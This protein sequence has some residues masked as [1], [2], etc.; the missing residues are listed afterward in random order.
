LRTVS[1]TASRPRRAWT[2]ALTWACAALLVGIAGCGGIKPKRSPE[3]TFDS[4]RKAIVEEDYEAMWGLLSAS[5]RQAE[6]ARISAQ[7]RRVEAELPNFSEA[8]K[9]RF[10]I[11]NGLSAEEFVNLS[12]AGA[13]ALGLRYSRQLGRDLRE[14]LENS[15]IKD[16]SVKGDGA[17]VTVGIAGETE[18]VRLALEKQSGLWRVPD[19]NSFLEG[20]DIAGRARRAGEIPADTYRAAVACVADQAYG[21]LWELFSTDGREWLAGIVK[22]DQKEV[23]GYDEDEARPFERSAGVTARAFVAMSPKEA[24][25]VEAKTG[26]GRLARL[27]RAL[28]GEFASADIAGEKATVTLRGRRGALLLERENGRWYFARM[29]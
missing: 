7:Q 29:E 12:P 9:E 26:V 15:K 1:Y 28:A 17:V 24:F 16:A 23:A 14:L 21:D 27:P 20:F 10:R 2:K 19:M 3:G 22:G 8:Q 6:S 25:V 4:I 5:A 18:P 13:F 11:E